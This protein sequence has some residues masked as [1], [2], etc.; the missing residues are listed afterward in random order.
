MRWRRRAEQEGKAQLFQALIEQPI[1]AGHA[2]P[3]TSIMQPTVI[4]LARF[5]ASTQSCRSF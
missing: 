1:T 4:L 3:E 5:S 2:R